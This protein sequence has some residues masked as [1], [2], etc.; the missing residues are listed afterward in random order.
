MNFVS[1]TVGIIWEPADWAIALS[2]GVQWYDG[3]GMLPLVPAAFG[4]NIGIAAARLIPAGWSDNVGR[5]VGHWDNLPAGT[6][7]QDWARYQ[8]HVTGVEGMEFI[9]NGVK[10]DGVIGSMNAAGNI[11]NLVLL[12]AK[13]WSEGF[14]KG[15]VYGNNAGAYES[16]ILQARQQIA[17]AN[18]VRIQ[19]HFSDEAAANLWRYALE[20]DGIH[21]IDVI[22]TPWAP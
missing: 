18:G 9:F 8:A 21:G 10:F 15:M 7:S 13:H 14:V 2:D 19:W 17:A 12:D 5:A 4:D 3:L 22:Y 6:L 1:T 16:K 11:D 20:R